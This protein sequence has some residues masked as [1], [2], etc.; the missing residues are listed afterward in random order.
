ME[1]PQDRAMSKADSQWKLDLIARDED[2]TDTTRE[3]AGVIPLTGI[4]ISVI[5]LRDGA[6]VLDPK[7]PSR[8][9]AR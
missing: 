4:E 9:V 7:A 1:L 3:L 8:S 5:T 6:L 2:L